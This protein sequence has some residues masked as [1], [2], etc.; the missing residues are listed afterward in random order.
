MFDSQRGKRLSP[1]F[2]IENYSEFVFDDRVK[3]GTG[4]FAYYVANQT[5]RRPDLPITI[6]DE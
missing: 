6:I 3:K 4:T 1:K 5:P 2:L